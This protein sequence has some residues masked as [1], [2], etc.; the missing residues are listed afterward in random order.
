MVSSPLFSAVPLMAFDGPGEDGAGTPWSPV[1]VSPRCPLWGVRVLARTVQ[2]PHGVLR[3]L[4]EPPSL[5]LCV[6]LSVDQ[7]SAMEVPSVGGVASTVAFSGVQ[8]F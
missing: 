3:A 8:L 7:V 2:A 5:V 6:L 4:R 1:L